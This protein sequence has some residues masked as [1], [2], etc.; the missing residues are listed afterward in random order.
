MNGLKG[1]I[2]TELERERGSNIK[3]GTIQN[4]KDS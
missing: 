2:Y 3:P 4:L 1:R